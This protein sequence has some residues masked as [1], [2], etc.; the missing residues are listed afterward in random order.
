MIRQLS[1]Q[2]QCRQ[3]L[4][5]ARRAIADQRLPMLARASWIDIVRRFGNAD[6]VKLLLPLFDCK[7][8]MAWP[9]R[10][11][12]MSPGNVINMSQVREVAVGSALLLLKKHPNDLGYSISDSEKPLEKPEESIHSTR[13]CIRPIKG[14]ESKEEVLEAA[15]AW[16][17][18]K[19]K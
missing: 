1:T 11:D 5:F 4:P 2:D 13:F 15:K 7:D 9:N 14:D 16:I 12:G 17:R 18:E 19:T 3:L 6:D 8:G 10:R